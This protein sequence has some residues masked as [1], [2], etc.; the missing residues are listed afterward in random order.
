MSSDFEAFKLNE[1]QRKYGT[2]NKKYHFEGQKTL[3]DL[4]GDY[5]NFVSIASVTT[6]PRYDVEVDDPE[7]L[8]TEFVCKLIKQ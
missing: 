5:R 2:R 4:R 8:I 3:D 6:D 1:Y 7:R